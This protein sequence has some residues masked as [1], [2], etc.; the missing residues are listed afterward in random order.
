MNDIAVR[1]PRLAP[2]IAIVASCVGLFS[3][4][5]IGARNNSYLPP[6]PPPRSPI[7]ISPP[8]LAF[9]PLPVGSI[10]PAQQLTLK[11]TSSQSIPIADISISRHDSFIR[12]TDCGHQLLGSKSCTVN[13]AFNPQSE[14]SLDTQMN[15]FSPG[16]QSVYVILRGTGTPRPQAPQMTPPS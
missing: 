6:P 13:I 1:P 4:C 14:G 5:G 11:N 9:D 16:F 2:T 3:A 10:S 15:I 8:G 12:T 7:K